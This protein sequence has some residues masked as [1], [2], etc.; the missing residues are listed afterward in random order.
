MNTKITLKH[1]NCGFSTTHQKLLDL[2]SKFQIGSWTMTESLS[3]S[4]PKIFFRP[5][6]FFGSRI[7]LD[8]KLFWTRKQIRFFWPKFYFQ[9]NFFFDAQFHAFVTSSPAYSKSD[10]SWTLKT[11]VLFS[12]FANSKMYYFSGS[13]ELFWAN[14]GY[15][16]LLL[17]ISAYFWL[18]RAIF[19]PPPRQNFLKVC[20]ANQG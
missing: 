16:R 2:V 17:A 19:I 4:P 20:C 3:P 14:S 18:S 11:L 12:S 13:L 8:S 7:S 1:I 15:L 5:N 6:F 10:T 9:P